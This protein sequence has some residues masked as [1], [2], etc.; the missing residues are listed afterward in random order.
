MTSVSYFDIKKLPLGKLKLIK[1]PIPNVLANW[2]FTQ[3]PQVRGNWAEYFY[4]NASGTLVKANKPLVEGVSLDGTYLQ[5]PPQLTTYGFLTGPVFEVKATS[6]QGKN[7]RW[8]FKP[9]NIQGLVD[10][11][12]YMIC[13]MIH[14]NHIWYAIFKYSDIYPIL[15]QSSRR[16]LNYVANSSYLF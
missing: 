2:L 11:D 9:D 3:T 14:F 15:N 4:N 1:L 5:G 16:K 8:T 10:L 13:A 7:P 12:G 6:S